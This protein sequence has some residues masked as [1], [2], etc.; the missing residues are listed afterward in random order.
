M[1]VGH[2]DLVGPWEIR[3]GFAYSVRFTFP[4][5]TDLTGYT[6]QAQAR[7]GPSA[8]VAYFDV[9]P[10][11]GQDGDS[12]WYVQLDLTDEE[13]AVL[14]ATNQGEWELALTSSG[15]SV[16]LGFEGKVDIKPG[17]IE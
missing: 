2:F 13:T 4:A 11:I 3:Q 1:P 17:L 7:R 12:L 15:G 5:D 8:S 9:V 16:D 14:P 6:A 10:T